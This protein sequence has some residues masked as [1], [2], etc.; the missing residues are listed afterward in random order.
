MPGSEVVSTDWGMLGLQIVSAIVAV[1]IIPTIPLV[2]RLVKAYFEAK[3]QAVEDR[4]KREAAEFALKRLDH[5]VNN[6]VDEITQTSDKIRGLS[7]EEKSERKS[8]AF[9]RIKAQLTPANEEVLQTQVRDLDRY[10]L[11]KIEASRLFQKSC[12]G[13]STST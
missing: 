8:G 10:I 7:E 5:I 6:V 3:I 13:Q 4:A 12:E 9:A 1:V 2:Y 11:T